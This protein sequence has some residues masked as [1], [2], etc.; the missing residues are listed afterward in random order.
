MI[1][2][3]ENLDIRIRD[4]IDDHMFGLRWWLR[5]TGDIPLEEMSSFFDARMEDYPYH[6]D[7]WTNAYLAFPGYL[8]AGIQDVLDLGCGY[9]KELDTVLPAFPGISVTGIDMSGAMLDELA[10][11]HPEVKRIRG[12]YCLT[13]FEE[14]SYDAV[15]SFESLHHLLPEP[16]LE[17]YRKIFRCL[18]PGG[19]FLNC[20]YFACCEEEEDLLRDVF[21]KKQKAEGL[22]PDIP[23]HFD[24]PLTLPHESDLL[25][26]AGFSS[27]KALSS[28]AGAC[29]LEAI[30]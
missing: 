30:R 17:L 8:P 19:I 13:P 16:K 9:G 7:R 20:D 18:R 4:S 11:R 1:M 22:S 10:R 21:L 26:S 5:E 29:F 15:I 28:H 27:C 25:E 6:M 12:N 2:V 24:I 14:S 3:R 23:V